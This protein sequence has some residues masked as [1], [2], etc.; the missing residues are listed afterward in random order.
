M[1][2]SGYF[3]FFTAFLEEGGGVRL[4]SLLKTTR[5][6]PWL[7]GM[8][9]PSLLIVLMSFAATAYSADRPNILWIS[10]ED[11][12]PLHPHQSRLPPA[13]KRQG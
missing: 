4:N 8:K 3:N 7:A 11:N 12:G 9:K 2:S 5:Y 1:I 6:A 10:S 13:I